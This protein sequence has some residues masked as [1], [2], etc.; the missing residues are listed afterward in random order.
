[1]EGGQPL[2]SSLERRTRARESSVGD[3]ARS[4]A[5]WVRARVATT[6]GR[7]VLI[8][9]LILVGAVGFGVVATGAERS[10]AQAAQAVRNETEPLLVQAVKLY[11]ALSDANATVTTTLLS[12]GLEPPLKRARYD[13][14]LRASSAALATLTREAGTS[15]A[16]RSA[17]AVISQQLP[18]Y[19]SL[20][21]SARANNRQG[22]PIGAAYL[23]QGSG[24]LTGIM[25]PAAGR[26]YAVEAQRLSDDYGSGT[27]TAAL[28]AFIGAVV[29]SLALLVIA[30]LYVARVSRRTFNLPMVAA[31]IVIVAVALWGIVGLVSA[32]NALASARSNGSD[33]V[34]VLSATRV[35]LSR[36][37]GDESLAL[38]N[39]GSDA[40]DATD[41]A[42]VMR[43]VG[44]L[45]PEVHVLAQRTGTIPAANRLDTEMAVYRAQ[46][47][48]LTNLQD[49]GQ[50]NY[51]ISRSSA[52]ADT[53]DRLSTDLSGQFTG[54][55]SR[56]E[57]S[58]AD[59]TAS[60]SGLS[61]AIPLL[62]ALAAVL[63]LFG[64]RER[65]NEYR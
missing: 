5:D 10:R 8:S 21:A 51:A 52:S 24:L 50:I 38:V 42:A 19:T 2:A 61:I 58:A 11:T 33:S 6:P 54:A 3:W 17:L 16:A 20:V 45:L 4:V 12:G 41:F 36:A 37:Q 34:E 15:A 56:F 63:A 62:V 25:L 28:V 53:A 13:H 26:L 29:V 35:L 32:Q 43:T 27:A 49:S 40:S 44:G 64:L 22:F 9:I 46:T 55:Q 47:G 48:Q 14:D 18:E 59:A 60:L 23:R 39:R 30:Q 1:M 31:T 57:R 7:L 65:I